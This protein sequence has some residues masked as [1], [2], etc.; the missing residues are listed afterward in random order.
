MD[1]DA[2]LCLTGQPRQIMYIAHAA[3]VN[4][5]DS[6]VNLANKRVPKALKVSTLLEP[7]Q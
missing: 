7:F 1:M 4:N 6:F 3:M 2:V 5:S